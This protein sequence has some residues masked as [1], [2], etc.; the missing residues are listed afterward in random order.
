MGLNTR[1]IKRI[2]N[3][4]TSDVMHSSGYAQVGNRGSFGAA[5]S[6][7]F[8]ERRRI[9]QNRKLVQAYKNARIAADVRM[10]P[11]AKN[12]AE[13]QVALAAEQ[14]RTERRLGKQEFNNRLEQGGLRQYD[15]RQQAISSINRTA[16]G[17]GGRVA[18]FD[19]QARPTPKTGGFMR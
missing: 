1:L 15:T 12:I 11:K 2:S 18:N 4:S 10:M 8:A 5:D 7:S 19:A 6:T 14:A 17:G 3:T 9:E 16:A 13:Q